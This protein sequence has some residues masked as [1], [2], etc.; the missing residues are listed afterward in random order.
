MFRSE[1]IADLPPWIC[2]AGQQRRYWLV[3]LWA[4]L[5]ML[6]C[7]QWVPGADWR[8]WWRDFTGF[9]ALAL[10]ALGLW[11]SLQLR[12]PARQW[13]IG[14]REARLLLMLA[15]PM[16]A[17]DSAAELPVRAAVVL[18]GLI[19]LTLHPDSRR[20]WVFSDECSEAAWRRLSLCARFARQDGVARLG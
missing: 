8:L 1:P 18:P 20:V 15:E 10:L 4:L 17:K 7:L 16:P 11:C 13:W 14:C 3:F 12:A 6:L 2:R 9:E 5:A 19:I